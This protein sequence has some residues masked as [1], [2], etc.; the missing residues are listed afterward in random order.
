MQIGHLLR[1]IDIVHKQKSV[2][3]STEHYQCTLCGKCYTTAKALDRHQVVN[4]GKVKRCLECH[5]VCNSDG[6]H[7]F[8]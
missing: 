2:C 6:K 8:L 3:A 5:H 4:H 7:L 1:H